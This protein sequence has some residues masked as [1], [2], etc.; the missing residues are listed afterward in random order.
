MDVEGEQMKT[1]DRHTTPYD[2]DSEA[3]ET[4]FF[5]IIW[6]PQLNGPLAKKPFGIGKGL[7]ITLI[8]LF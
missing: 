7:D 8:L 4:E 2:I 6:S 1:R 5:L 3:E